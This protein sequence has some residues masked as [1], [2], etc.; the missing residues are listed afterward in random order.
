MSGARQHFLPQF[1]QRGFTTIPGGERTWLY[2][3]EA[4]PREVGLRDVGVAT[5]FYTDVDSAIDDAITALEGTE[6]SAVVAKAREAAP[7]PFTDSAIPKLFAHLEVRSR[8][9]REGFLTVADRVTQRLLERI[10]T[11]NVLEQILARRMTRQRTSM[12]ANIRQELRAQKKPKGLASQILRE[13]NKSIPGMVRS[14][15]VQSMAAQLRSLLSLAMKEGAKLGHLNA[16]R[17]SL[18][19]HVRI[20]L[21]APLQFWV[22]EV[23]AQNVILGDSG[24]FF[25]VDRDDKFK[26]FVDKNVNV[27]AALMPISSSRILIGSKRGSFAIDPAELNHHIAS[28]SFD[29]F[30]AAGSSDENCA[31]QPLIQSEALPLSNAEIDAMVAKIVDAELN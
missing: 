10:A 16:L 9:L 31:L 7:G 6:F 11:P 1:I 3:R 23:P 14:P 28:C 17:K 18:S 26:P 20:D 30:I 25:R 29:F 2:R 5:N 24:V 21:Y 15:Q 12:L 27:I 13:A 19:P 22:E 4:E 8:N